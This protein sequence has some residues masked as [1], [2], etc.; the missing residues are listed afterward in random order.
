[1]NEQLWTTFKVVAELGAISRAA[2]RLNLSTSAVSQQITQL[3]QHYA[4]KLFLRTGHGV[5]LTESGELLYRYV[6]TL[7][8]TIAESKRQMDQ[9]NHGTS[10]TVSIA[11][12]FT[13]A[14]YILPKIL[15][16]YRL[17]TEARML[18]TMVNSQAIMDQVIHGEVAV[19]LIEAA[20]A[21]PEVIVR[22]F[23]TDRLLIAVAKDHPFASRHFIEIEEFMAEPVIL[24]EPGSGTRLV[25][26]TS[27]S[28]LGLGLENLNVQMV[29]GTTQAIKAM[30]AAG[31][32][33]SAI[34]PL[35]IAPEERRH[36][37]LL[38]VRGLDLYRPF[39][40]V[41]REDRSPTVDHFVETVLR[42]P[43]HETLNGSGQWV[44]PGVDGASHGT[45]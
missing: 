16:R 19:G 13:V 7:L 32:G 18:V 31:V 20:L 2:R 8:N 35:V 39:S 4:T 28:A 22:P 15:P 44:T 40:V 9:L 14:E 27:L 25:L 33:I 43:W 23:W 36:F 1:M 11:A 21:H 10:Q 30:V 6:L 26:E 37:H 3:E 24:R 5:V 38:T 12:S 45:R 41:Y 42:W 29:L 34:C 17:T